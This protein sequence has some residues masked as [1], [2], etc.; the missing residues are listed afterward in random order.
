MDE[1][2]LRR[3]VRERALEGVRA[4][5]ARHEHD[6][7]A[8]FAIPKRHRHVAGQQERRDRVPVDGL[9][10][11]GRLKLV[12]AGPR[13][14]ARENRES[15]EGRG[16]SGDVLDA[17]PSARLLADVRLKQPGGPA[18]RVLQLLLN[19][20]GPRTILAEDENGIGAFGNQKGRRRNAEPARAAHDENGASRERPPSIVELQLVLA[21][22]FLGIEMGARH[23]GRDLSAPGEGG[24]RERPCGGRR[25]RRVA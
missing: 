6:R 2:G 21:P 23:G 17:A 5:H 3:A 22:D 11:R 16:H 14:I 20:F 24:P 1:R 12:R 10:E 13:R 15:R 8:L 7:A 9:A 4:L 25:Y 18:P 19:Q